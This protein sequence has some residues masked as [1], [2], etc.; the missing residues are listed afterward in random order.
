MTCGLIF[1][2]ELDY[3]T[4]DFMPLL[5][6]NLQHFTAPVKLQVFLMYIQGSLAVRVIIKQFTAVV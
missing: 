3:V 6:A 5:G 4:T 2:Y 1:L